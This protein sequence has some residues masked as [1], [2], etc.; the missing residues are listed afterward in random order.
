MGRYFYSHL[1]DTDSL[2]SDLAELDLTESQRKELLEI[3]HVHTHQAVVDA[4]L[5]E[6]SDKDKKKFLELLAL[7]SDDEIWKHLNEKVEKIEDKITD[8]AKQVKRELREDVKKV[9]QS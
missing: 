6:L 1:T 7:G 8:V 9:K 3:A 5:S 2:T 4:I